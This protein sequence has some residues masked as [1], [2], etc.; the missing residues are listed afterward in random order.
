MTTTTLL[1]QLDLLAR[2]ANTA[3][4]DFAIQRGPLGWRV[5]LAWLRTPTAARWVSPWCVELGDACTT[6]LTALRNEE[7][8]R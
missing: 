8:P 4:K 2:A 5:T 7:R 3:Q 1:E 6:A